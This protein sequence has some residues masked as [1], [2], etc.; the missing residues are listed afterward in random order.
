MTFDTVQT[1]NEYR[2]WS[3]LLKVTLI[4]NLIDGLFTLYYLNLGV[5]TE[6][7]P[8]LDFFYMK[9]PLYFVSVK[10]M[11]CCGGVYL[12]YKCLGSRF[13][14][15]GAAAVTAVYTAVNGYHLAFFGSHGLPFLT[16]SKTV[17]SAKLLASL[18]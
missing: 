18:F 17:V 4:L 5:A 12:L 14:Q 15:T 8:I 16:D 1:F 9:H 13:A 2:F 7:N 11:L 3:R 6:A 10:M